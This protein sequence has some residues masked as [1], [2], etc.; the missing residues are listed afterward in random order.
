MYLK[1]LDLGKEVKCDCKD[2]SGTGVYKGWREQR[3]L[4]VEGE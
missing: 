4:G 2:C 1:E 3:D